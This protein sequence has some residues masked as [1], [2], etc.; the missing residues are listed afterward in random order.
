MS[1]NITALIILTLIFSI[2]CK[3][4]DYSKNSL[5]IGLGIGINE[6]MRET[7]MG[8]LVSIGFQKSIANDRIRI[9]PNYMSGGFMPLAITDTRD[10]YYRISSLGINGSLDAI[11]TG[12]FSLFVSVGPHINFTRGL[13]GTGG[14]PEAG[15]TSSD[16]IFKL[17]FAGTAACGIRINK[18]AS[19]FAFEYLPFNISY[20][21][22]NF[23]L[24]YQ[25]VSLDIKLKNKN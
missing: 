4:Q 19:R 6:G 12:S 23:M 16:Y 9:N 21:T 11:K 17:Y 14:W 22:D 5:R 20:G 24:L 1:R 7:G 18:P 15:N 2:K 13:L 25:K 3:C 10:Q 8:A